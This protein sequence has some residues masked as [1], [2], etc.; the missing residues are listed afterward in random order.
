MFHILKHKKL[1][2]ITLLLIFYKWYFQL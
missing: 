1:N 2:K